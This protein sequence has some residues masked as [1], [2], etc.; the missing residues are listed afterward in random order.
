MLEIVDEED[1]FSLARRGPQLIDERSRVQLANAQ[2]LGEDGANQPVIPH[3]RERNEADV[4]T[5]GNRGQGKAC[6]ANAARSSEGQKPHIASVEKPSD[7]GD[8]PLPT[9]EARQQRWKRMVCA[10]F[11]LERGHGAYR[12]CSGTCLGHRT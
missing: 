12:P 9:Y 10:G 3:S 4:F 11:G 5:I 6:L 8:L 7:L 1:G 2:R